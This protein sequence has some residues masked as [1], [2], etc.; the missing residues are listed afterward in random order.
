MDLEERELGR[1]LRSRMKLLTTAELG[2]LLEV[3]LATLTKWRYLKNGPD[4]VKLGNLVYY[5]EDQVATW[6][7]RNRREREQPELEKH[8]W[9]VSFAPRLPSTV[10]SE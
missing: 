6:L 10:T 4:Y 1:E 3:S 9:D 7:E 2:L 5:F 8:N